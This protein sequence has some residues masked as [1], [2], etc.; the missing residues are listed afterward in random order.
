MNE[1]REF[2]RIKDRLEIEFREIDEDE[3]FQLEHEIKYRPSYQYRPD[4]YMDPGDEGRRREDKRDLLVPY[5]REIDRKLSTILNLLSPSSHD[6]Q[7]DQEKTFTAYYGEVEIS[8]AGLSFVFQ[9]PIPEGTLLHMKVMLP[10]FPYPA[11]R[12]LCEVVSIRQVSGD[13][14]VGWKE[15]LKFLVIND[16]DRDLLI[17]YVFDKEGRVRLFFKHGQGVDPIVADLKRLL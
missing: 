15:A 6:P 11:V 3:F 1:K 12:M 5:L 9:A 2:F 7:N 13:D 10:I 14:S 16:L 17:S 4:S 8:G